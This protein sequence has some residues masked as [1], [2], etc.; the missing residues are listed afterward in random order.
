MASK[1]KVVVPSNVAQVQDSLDQI[2]K[3]RTHVASISIDSSLNAIIVKL[4]GKA[5][6]FGYDDMEIPLA[7]GKAGEAQRLIDRLSSQITSGHPAS[8]SDASELFG[9][10][11]H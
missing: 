11:Q 1:Y 8:P 9:L 4:D 2:F 10:I 3:S 7:R 6:F 5:H